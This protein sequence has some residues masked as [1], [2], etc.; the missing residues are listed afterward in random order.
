MFWTRKDNSIFTGPT[1]LFTIWKYLDRDL[2]LVLE[3]R[4]VMKLSA[5]E[6]IT[7][8]AKLTVKTQNLLVHY[9]QRQLFNCD[10]LETILEIQFFMVK[11]CS[12]F[13]FGLR[14][15]NT[16]QRLTETSSFSQEF[17]FLLHLTLRLAAGFTFKATTKI[18]E[19]WKNSVRHLLFW[20]FHKS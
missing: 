16:R 12:S 18:I 17:S 20:T 19:E 10:V 4:R 13:Q 14:C 3:Q 15:H 9:I 11:L 2:C 7:F 8:S 5:G 6:S 1:W